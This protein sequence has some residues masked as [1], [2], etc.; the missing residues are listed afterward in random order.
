MSAAPPEHPGRALRI[1][2]ACAVVLLL[3]GT[4]GGLFGLAAYK[5]LSACARSADV[6]LASGTRLRVC[7]PPNHT[8]ECTLRMPAP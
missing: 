8:A 6:V 2:G 4:F 1:A 5:D 7:C 3:L